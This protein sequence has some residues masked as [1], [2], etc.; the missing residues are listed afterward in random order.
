MMMESLGVNIGTAFSES[1]KER[2]VAIVCAV[3]VA[4]MAIGVFHA[5][6]QPILLGCG[7]SVS[8]LVFWSCLRRVLNR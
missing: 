7:G 1:V 5:P 8:M 4:V 6:Y 2:R 3:A